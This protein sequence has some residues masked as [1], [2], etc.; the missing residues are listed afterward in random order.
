MPKTTKLVDHCIGDHLDSPA[1]KPPGFL[2]RPVWLFRV[3]MLLLLDR[4]LHF[5]GLRGGI[6]RLLGVDRS[7]KNPNL[8]NM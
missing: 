6:W 1:P 4:K 8:C 2:R 3:P 7:P 5:T